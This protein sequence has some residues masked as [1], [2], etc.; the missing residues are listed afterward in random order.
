MENILQK[1]KHLSFAKVCSQKNSKRSHDIP[2]KTL[3]LN[4]F[5]FGPHDYHHQYGI[6]VIET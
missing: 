2:G 3:T 1:K 4:K 6:S 5:K